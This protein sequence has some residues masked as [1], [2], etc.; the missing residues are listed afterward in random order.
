MPPL[1]PH[2]GTRL[3]PSWRLFS[4][5]PLSGDDNM[6]IDLETLVGVEEGHLPPTL[7]FFRW[8]QPTV[9]YGRLQ[10]LADVQPAIPA[11]WAAVRRPT[12]GGVVF[13]ENDL[14]LSLSWPHDHPLLP[15]KPT[16]QYA[17]IHRVILEALT[18]II[19]LRLASCCETRAEF[20]PGGARKCFDYPVGYDLL[21]DENKIVGG[22][23]ARRRHASLYQGSIQGIA[24]PQLESRL[25][26]TFLRRFDPPCQPTFR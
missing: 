25:R 5:A 22:A 16:E 9:S 20:A 19:P 10:K 13:H 12:A 8:A 17:W 26:Q 4:T 6:R 23:L 7:R 14:C 2:R 18:P 15:P 3:L 1:A 11:G 21:S 24:D